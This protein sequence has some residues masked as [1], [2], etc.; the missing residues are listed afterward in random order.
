[1]PDQKSN[2]IREL[3]LRN[4][5]ELLDYLKRRVGP[6]D[7]ADL[8]QETFLRALRREDHGAIADPPAFLQQIAIN[9]TRDFARRRRTEANCLVFGDLPDEAPSKEATPGDLF[10]ADEE[11]RLLRQAVDALPPRCRE[12]FILYVSARLSPAEIAKRL[13]ISTNMAQKHI[14]LALQRCR[15]AL[16]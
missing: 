5:R 12:A 9:L 4:K 16:E 2:F 11:S 15:M 7:A 14:R 6:D 10:E 13:G 8:L 3:F 1:M